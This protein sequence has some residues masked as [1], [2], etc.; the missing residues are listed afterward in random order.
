MKNLEILV[1]ED[2][3][4]TAL[5]LKDKL[6]KLGYIVPQICSTGQKAIQTAAQIHPDLVLMDIVLKGETDGIQAAEKIQKLNIPVIYLTAYSDQ[7]TINKIKK[8]PS[9]GYIIKPYNE[10]ELQTNIEMAIQKHKQEETIIESFEDQVEEEYKKRKIK[11]Y[12]K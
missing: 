7:Q 12:K 8:Q 11:M 1:V 2:E 6:E 4:I 5:D 3:S 10:K 9:Y